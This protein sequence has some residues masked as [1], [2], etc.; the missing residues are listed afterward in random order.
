MTLFLEEDELAIVS[1]CRKSR[2][3]RGTATYEVRQEKYFIRFDHS[4]SLDLKSFVA[5]QRYLHS[6]AR[7]AD[8]IRIP[9]IVHEF[10]HDEGNRQTTYIVMPFIPFLDPPPADKDA[11]IQ[12]AARWLATVAAPKGHKL[13]PLGGGPMIHRFFKDGEA[14][15]AYADVE[16]L[17]RFMENGRQRLPAHERKTHF[18]RL[19]GEP[20]V[21]IQGNVNMNDERFGIDTDG[22]VVVM[23][24]RSV[25][26][27]PHSL[28][29]YAY[30]SS[31]DKLNG[32]ADE[33]G[34]IGADNQL[35]MAY[36]SWILK[37]TSDGALGLD[38]YGRPNPAQC[39]ERLASFA[40][41]ECFL[42]IRFVPQGLD[43]GDLGIWFMKPSN[44]R[45]GLPTYPRSTLSLPQDIALLASTESYFPKLYL[46]TRMTLFLEEDELA[47]V[48]ECRK[49]RRSRGTVT[50][51]VGQEKY[52]IRFDLSN[53]L[54]IKAF[55]ANQQYLQSVARNADGIRI[56]EIVHE[57]THDEGNRQTTYIVMPFI[58]F[59]DPPPADKDAKIQEA[60]RWLATVVAPKGHKLGP[61]G[62]GPM[63]H[64]FFKF[65]EAEVA[66]ADVES[67]E[68]FMDEGRRRMP[69]HKTKTHSFRL[70]GEPLVC[71]QGNIID[72]R[73]GIDPDG[74]VVVMGLRSITWVP[75]SFGRFAYSCSKELDGIP[76]ELG[77]MGADNQSTM[78][79]ISHILN[80][81]SGGGT[82]GLDEYGRP[83]PA[84]Y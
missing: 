38:E 30:M 81:M 60:A 54:Y 27:V 5:T 78:L 57:F 84:Q 39:R 42:E 76:D 59:L 80:M 34:W 24:L 75:H 46:F 33:L 69:T 82:L 56:A 8:H 17:E 20:L 32:I 12:E 53:S 2:L 79:P 74:N 4:K 66:Y 41:V 52:F 51:N 71:I 47:I 72:E 19:T 77:W 35:T 50:Y 55:V 21:C 31:K 68:R 13:G 28:A 48:S 14:D 61:L 64:P 62:G 11:K 7:N 29:R 70:T 58:P 37:M 26:W 65:D 15:V 63:I 45:Q 22:N 16:S 25:A 1:E 43:V 36:I 73:F 40:L 49:T 23:G 6:V 3:Y 44:F 67:L 9:E 18:V 10:T 83:D